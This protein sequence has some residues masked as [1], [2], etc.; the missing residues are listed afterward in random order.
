MATHNIVVFGGDHCGPDVSLNRGFGRWYEIGL[1][2]EA[3]G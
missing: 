2:R 1:C 3:N